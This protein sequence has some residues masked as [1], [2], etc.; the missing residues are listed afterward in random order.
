MKV[1]EDSFLSVDEVRSYLTQILAAVAFLHAN[2][3]I[4]ANLAPIHILVGQNGLIELISF[5]YA[6]APALRGHDNLLYMGFLW[7]QPPELILDNDSYS[8]AIDMWSVGCLMAEMLRGRTLFPGMS[9]IELVQLQFELMGTPNEAMWP[10][11]GGNSLLRNIPF[12]PPQPWITDRSEGL[13]STLRHPRQLSVSF[14]SVTCMFVILI[15]FS[16]ICLI[17]FKLYRAFGT[18][19]FVVAVI[20]YLVGDGE[21]E[22]HGQKRKTNAQ[23][24]TERNIHLRRE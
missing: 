19:C 4:H 22:D 7:V 12:F 23:N 15:C 13:F 11:I 2:D 1:L 21:N 18:K 6:R 16:A 20:L 24:I 3:I 5:E 9:K 14:A 8:T 10:G 17:L